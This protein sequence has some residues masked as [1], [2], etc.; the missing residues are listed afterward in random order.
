MK[1]WQEQ[2]VDDKKDLDEKIGKLAKFLR[3]TDLSTISDDECLR[4]KIQISLM[5][6]YSDILAF[7][8][9]HFND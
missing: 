2:V 6:V 4:L 3:D 9:N 8:I 7:R 1:D 5:G